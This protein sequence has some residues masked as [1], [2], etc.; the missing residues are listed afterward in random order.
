MAVFQ[1][2]AA[3]IDQNIVWSLRRSQCISH[4]L[5]D[6]ELSEC[7]QVCLIPHNRRNNSLSCLFKPV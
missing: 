3:N 5:D 4:M 6:S 7:G 1:T 2:S